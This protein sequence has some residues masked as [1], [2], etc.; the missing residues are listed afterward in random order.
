MVPATLKTTILEALPETAVLRLPVPASFRFV[1]SITAPPRPP[2]AFFQN[3]PH[4]GKQM[5][6]P[7]QD[8]EQEDLQEG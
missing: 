2:V 6:F 3:P 8:F 1:T 5:L 4:Q 7:E